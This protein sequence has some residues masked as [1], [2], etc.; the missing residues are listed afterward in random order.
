MIRRPP[1]STLFPYT[2]LFRSDRHVHR[3]VGGLERPEASHQ[4]RV[5]RHVPVVVGREPR[6]ALDDPGRLPER[7]QIFP[8]AAERAHDVEV[9]D[10]ERVAPARV[11]EDQLAEREQLER[12]A[13]PRARPPRRLRDPP[14]LPVLARVEADDEVALAD[15]EGADHDRGRA[16]EAHLRRSA[17]TRTRAGPARP[18]PPPRAAP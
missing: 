12:A 16:P 10:P 11:E 13:E 3:A 18:P 14:D 15:G 6:D 8:Q 4:E 17:G 1:R 5:E 9:V 2:T 7:L